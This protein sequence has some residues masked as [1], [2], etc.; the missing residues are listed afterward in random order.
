MDG[1]VKCDRCSARALREFVLDK[2]VEGRDLVLY[3]CLHHSA[4]WAPDQPRN[5][6][7]DLEPMTLTGYLG[8]DLLAELDKEFPVSV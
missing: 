1:Y 5:V 7:F 2:Q 6:R 4:Q 8:T 3:G